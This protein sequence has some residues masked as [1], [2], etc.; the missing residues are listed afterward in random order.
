MLKSGPTIHRKPYRLSDTCTYNIV[1]N[2]PYLLLIHCCIWYVVFLSDNMCEHHGVLY[3]K[4]G[5]YK[6]ESHKQ[7]ITHNLHYYQYI[8]IFVIRPCVRV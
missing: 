1:H 3:S 6:H 5:L 8:K 7:W 2:S 4:E